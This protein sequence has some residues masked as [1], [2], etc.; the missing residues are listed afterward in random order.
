LLNIG[1]DTKKEKGVLLI[2]IFLGVGDTG[3][4]PKGDILGQAILWVRT[5]PGL[6]FP[7]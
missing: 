3:N 4:G 6:G 2:L 1:E 5:N 7:A